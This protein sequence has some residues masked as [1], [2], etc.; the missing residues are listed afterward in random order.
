MYDHYGVPYSRS[1][2]AEHF[3]QSRLAY[4]SIL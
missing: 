1:F 3:V 4:L 2:E